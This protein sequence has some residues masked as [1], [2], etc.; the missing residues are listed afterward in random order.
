MALLGVVVGVLFG[1]GLLRMTR[2]RSCCW[3]RAPHLSALQ[4]THAGAGR[5]EALRSTHRKTTR[6][7]S[8]IPLNSGEGLRAA[9]YVEDDRQVTPR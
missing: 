3:Q 9:Y 6:K 8:E 2:F 4:N 7:P 5:T 1:I